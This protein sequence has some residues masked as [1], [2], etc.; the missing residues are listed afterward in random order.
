MKDNTGPLKETSDRLKAIDKVLPPNLPEDQFQ[1]ID[2]VYWC[3]TDPERRDLHGEW[4]LGDGAWNNVGTHMRWQPGLI[5]L[6]D[7][8]LRHAFGLPANAPLPHYMAIHIRRGDFSDMWKRVTPRMYAYRAW[9]VLRDAATAGISA[10]KVIVTTDEKDPEWLDQLR[11]YGFIIV[12]HTAAKTGERLG[13]WMPT[14]LDAVLLSRA[15]VLVGVP[16]STSE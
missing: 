3:H 16:A 9:Q 1:C 13:W 15:K 4:H 11:A 12:D 10:S 6:A 2:S 7:D 14:V 8:Y 5:Q